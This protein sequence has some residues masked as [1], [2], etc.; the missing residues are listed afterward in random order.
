MTTT[1]IKNQGFLRSYNVNGKSIEE[2]YI[3][4]NGE[5][6]LHSR[7][8]WLE[9]VTEDF[10]SEYCGDLIEITMDGEIKRAN[11]LNLNRKDN[12]ICKLPK[13]WYVNSGYCLFIHADNFL[14]SWEELPKQYLAEKAHTEEGK[15]SYLYGYKVKLKH[16]AK[17]YEMYLKYYH[18]GEEIKEEDKRKD[19]HYAVL[20]DENGKILK[21]E[22]GY[23][24]HDE[25]TM[26]CVRRKVVEIK[27]CNFY[28]GLYINS[29]K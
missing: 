17:K 2:I 11:K 25:N 13:S 27:E 19:F 3:Y 29:G 12:F 7:R 9:T 10:K 15:T 6:L 23:P 18:N 20:K 21:D 14:E 26:Y 5:I 4:K 28:N 22:N 16:F 8:S 1:T 24:I